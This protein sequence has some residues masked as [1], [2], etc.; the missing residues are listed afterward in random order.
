MRAS[1]KSSIV[2]TRHSQILT[3][4]QQIISIQLSLDKTFSPNVKV[5]KFVSLITWN[6]TL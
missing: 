1:N 4:V 5:K 6:N 3:I 2:K